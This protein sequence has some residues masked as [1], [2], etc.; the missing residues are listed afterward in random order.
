MGYQW[1]TFPDRLPLD[2]VF[3]LVSADLGQPMLHP[4][5]LLRLLLLPKDRGAVG[6]LGSSARPPYTARS[7]TRRRDRTAMGALVRDLIERPR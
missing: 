5:H 4:T 3:P 7:Y 1:G 6:G 2:R